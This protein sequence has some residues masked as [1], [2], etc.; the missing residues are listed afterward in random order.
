MARCSTSA[1]GGRAEPGGAGRGW[2]QLARLAA[3]AAAVHLAA[4]D[5]GRMPI[6]RRSPRGARLG[7]RGGGAG[8]RGA[9]ARLMAL[10]RELDAYPEVPAMLRA[11]RGGRRGDPVE[12]TRHAGAAVRGGLASVRRGAVG[13]G[14]RRFKPAR[15]VYDLGGPRCAPD[16]VVSRTAGTRLRA[17]TASHVWANRGRAGDRLPWRPT[18]CSDLRGAGGAADPGERFAPRTGC[19][20]PTGRGR[21]CRCCACRADPQR[22]DFEPVAALAGGAGDPARPAR[23]GRVAARSGVSELQHP[24]RGRTRWSCST[25]SG[26]A[27]GDLG[28]SRGGM[29]AMM[30]AALAPG[31]AGGR[32]PER[33]RA[34]DRARR[35][36]RGS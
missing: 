28:T 24:A 32:D 15:A 25:I 31:A 1:R 9:A 26:R 13:R 3:E 6:S 22:A 23:A 35:G 20:S 19:R 10:Y 21:G 34:G 27:R 29:I 12:R 5:R 11:A 18:T 33:H 17:G 4:D 8:G 7:A 14:G 36:W 2:P 16:G 30:L